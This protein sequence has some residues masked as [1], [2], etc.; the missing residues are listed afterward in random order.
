MY[1]HIKCA[2]AL[3]YVRTQSEADNLTKDLIVMRLW[4]HQ[5]YH[6]PCF[7]SDRIMQREMTPGTNKMMR[8]CRDKREEK[9]PLG[10]SN[11]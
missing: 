1:V 3:L 11:R 5:F 7:T 9:K 8:K 2:K 10:E 6:T 4:L